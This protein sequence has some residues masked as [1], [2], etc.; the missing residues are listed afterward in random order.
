MRHVSQSAAFVPHFNQPKCGI[1][2]SDYRVDIGKRIA[3]IRGV[4][5]QQAFAAKIGVHKNT[6][7]NY[8]RGERTPDAEFLSK[9]AN[10]GVNTHWVITGEGAMSTEDGGRQDATPS[11]SQAGQIAA[12]TIQYGHIDPDLFSEV[13]QIIRSKESQWR[14]VDIVHLLN[15]IIAM[16]NS[17]IDC[18]S[19]QKRKLIL[20]LRLNSLNQLAIS[21]SIS[22]IANSARSNQSDEETAKLAQAAIEEN[23]SILLDLRREERQLK[24][25]LSKLSD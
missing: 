13:I 22:S 3:Y 17:A 19:V 5:S 10:I 8:E 21:H 1:Q 4:S 6:L 2:M 24:S 15:E 14:G 23:E 7:G 18:P 11:A 9:L 20:K 25:D 12:R 16:Y